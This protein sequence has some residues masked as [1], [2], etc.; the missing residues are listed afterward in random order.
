M[1]RDLVAAPVV[2]RREVEA[3][4]PRSARRKIK[5]M[6]R[7]YAAKIVLAL[8]YIQE[9]SWASTELDRCNWRSE[10]SICSNINNVDRACFLGR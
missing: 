6:T 7:Q 8:G 3:V 4:Q 1:L 5:R 9:H 2:S 10:K